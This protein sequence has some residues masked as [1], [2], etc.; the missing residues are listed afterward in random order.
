MDNSER[1]RQLH[2][3][4]LVVDA[5][6]DTLLRIWSGERTLGERSTRG[7]IDLPRLADGGVDVQFFAC[8]IEAEH[9]PDRGLR[10]VM[11]L[12]DLFHREL[13]ANE[14]RMMLVLTA[15]DFEAAKAAGKVGAVLTIEGG[16]AIGDDLAA[17]R[18]LHRLGLRGL[19]L[20]W[21]QRNLIA[22]GVDESRTNGG[23]TRFGV[24]VVR[25]C[26]RIGILIDVSHLSEAGFWDV[27]EVSSK[28]IIAS[29]SNSR[30]V[31][32]H[33][34]NLS[35]DQVRALAANDGVMGM[36]FAPGFLTRLDLRAKT[37]EE[38]REQVKGKTSIESVI[39]HIDH[40]LELV[41]PDHIGLGSDFDGTSA[42]PDGLEDV[43]RLPALTEAM[44]RHGYSDEV[45]EKIMGRNL[46]R[47]FKEAVG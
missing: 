19:G 37:V 21:N 43:S 3:R 12:V 20:T 38:Y 40:L 1:A 16:E 28:P 14:G 27:L 30:A 8:Y 29:H 2:R 7:H 44:V 31:C 42:T 46:Q 9:K 47:V 33:P 24:D 10:R 15:A 11:Q 13:A 17:L 23:L 26:N 34:R 39:R 45:I 25:E 22:D 32:D 5:H 18:N 4:A 6:A 35:D 41:G 36:N